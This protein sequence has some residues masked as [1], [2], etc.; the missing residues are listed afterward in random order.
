[1]SVR[2]V[3]EGRLHSISADH[4]SNPKNELMIEKSTKLGRP[5]VKAEIEEAYKELNAEKKIDFAKSMKSQFNLIRIWLCRKYPDREGQF[6]ILADET[7]RKEF[8]PLFKADK[9]NQ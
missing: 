2:A 9:Q 7:I 8:S 6:S 5:S 4:L 3:P 1:M